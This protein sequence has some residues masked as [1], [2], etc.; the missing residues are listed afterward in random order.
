[1]QYFIPPPIDVHQIFGLEPTADLI[2]GH[3]RW[4][5]SIVKPAVVH[6]PV[7]AGVS[8]ISR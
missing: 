2:V 3:R 8:H 1:M 4:R 7:F 5:W 6:L